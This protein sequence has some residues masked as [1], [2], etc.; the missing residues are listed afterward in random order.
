[1]RTSSSYWIVATILLLKNHDQIINIT[2]IIFQFLLFDFNTQKAHKKLAGEVFDLK[3]ELLR[4]GDNDVDEEKNSDKDTEE[5]E[6]EAEQDYPD[7]W[8]DCMCICALCRVLVVHV[9]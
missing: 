4:E 1:M 6:E 7:L 2:T 5:A 9:A 8:V 3:E